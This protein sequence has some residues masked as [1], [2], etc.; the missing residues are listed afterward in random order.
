MKELLTLRDATVLAGGVPIL[1]G[2]SI[3]V[4]EGELIIIIGANGSG[5]TTLIRAL[6]GLV[7]LD[8]GEAQLQGKPLTSMG[9]R[10]RA[11]V[12]AWL[13]QEGTTIDALR[14][15]DVV[16]SSRYRFDEPHRTALAAAHSALE[17][18]GAVDLAQRW[19][20]E[21][22]GGERQRVE[23]ASLVAQQARCWLLDEPANHLDPAWR[24]R[25]LQFL[26]KKVS[27][28]TTA[29]VALHDIH[30]LGHI[31]NSR[32]RIVG[33]RDG[34]IVWQG[35]LDDENFGAGLEQIHGV[36]FQRIESEGREFWLPRG[37]ELP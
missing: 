6:L 26:D 29:L 21:L 24:A 12:M 19:L 15:E 36:P 8:S 34:K 20:T 13:P 32:T 10:Q 9:A 31:D 27:E 7:S 28:G 14:V 22:S 3:A 35:R 23:L 16:A 30:L 37:E 4:G 33:L 2:V 11:S 18:V 1:D 5:K 25:T 17:Q